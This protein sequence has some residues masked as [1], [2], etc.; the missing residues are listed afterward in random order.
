MSQFERFTN[1]KNQVKILVEKRKEHN[2]ADRFETRAEQFREP[3]EVLKNTAMH[4]MVL[5]AGG[6]ALSGINIEDLRYWQGRLGGLLVKF[7]ETPISILDPVAPGEDAR[8]VLLNPLQQLKIKLDEMAKMSWRSWVEQQG[9]KISPDV[10]N[11][12]S[13]V[14]TLRASVQSIIFLQ[15]RL[16]HAA[17]SLPDSA[18][19]I[20]AARALGQN[21]Q[22]AWQGLAGTGIPESVIFFLRAAGQQNGAAFGLL[23]DEVR[24]W[25]GEHQLM[26]SLKVKLF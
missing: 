26:T 25:L 3:S 5:D 4:A 17:N 15:E 11:V 22:D 1:L 12:L 7:R 14:P 6:I 24:D 8:R 16:R 19:A 23:T 10:L 20:S 18:D 13:G 9:P 21:L 2:K